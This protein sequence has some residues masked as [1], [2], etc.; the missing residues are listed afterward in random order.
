MIGGSELRKATIFFALLGFSMLFLAGL[1]ISGCGKE[2]VIIRYREIPPAVEL[3]SPANDSLIYENNPTFVWHI[4]DSSVRYQ[5]QVSAASDF[6]IK[7]LNVEIADTVYTTVTA[8]ANGSFY[9]RVRSMN[10]DNV[11]SDWSD[12]DIWIFY[13]TDNIYYI[14]FVSSIVTVGTAQDVAVRNDTAYVA[15]GAA[16]LTMVEVINKASPTILKNIDT[17]G[18]DYAMSV[19]INPQDTVPYAFVADLDGRIQVLNT[20]D[21]RPENHNGFGDQN[22]EDLAGVFISDTLYIFGVR[23][24]SGFNLA[25]LQIYQILYEPNLPPQPGPWP[26]NP[27]DTPADARGIF[28]DTA[29]AYVACDVVGLIIID[30]GDIYNPFILSGLD[31]EGVSL[32][33]FAKGDYVFVAADRAG[34]YVIDVTDRANPIISSQINTSGRTK[35]VHVVGDYAF[36]ADGSGGLKVIDASVP[37]SAH[38]VAAYTA[39]YAYGVYADSGYVYI[40]DRD[41]G[42]MIFENLVVE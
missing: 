15:D 20:F 2:K 27:I 37:D 3:I 35:D 18:D 7:S 38:F 16:D 39:P 30:L 12:A 6:V 19:Y 8:L 29:W 24:A 31:L 36:I 11:W 33:V 10:Q 28:V 42:L 17:I 1:L 21:P 13:K 22:I 26:W 5:V 4:V 41:M 14:P 23:S 25:G 40:C 32:K 9:W 34:L